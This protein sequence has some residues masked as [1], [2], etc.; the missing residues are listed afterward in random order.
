MIRSC[1]EPSGPGRA[2]G[3]RAGP[4]RVVASDA[5]ARL[6]RCALGVDLGHKREPFAVHG[7]DH[8]LF[9]SVVT[10]RSPSGGDAV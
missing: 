2:D 6:D 7:P 10:G 9:P 3:P 5:T 8:L 4:I 1:L